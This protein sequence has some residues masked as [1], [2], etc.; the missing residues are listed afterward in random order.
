MDANKAVIAAYPGP[1]DKTYKSV[2]AKLGEP[3]KKGDNM[4]EWFTMDGGKCVSFFM[5]K[6]AKKGHAA[7]GINGDADASSCK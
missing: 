4:F 3:M 1:F 2:V 5:T 6:D 7:S